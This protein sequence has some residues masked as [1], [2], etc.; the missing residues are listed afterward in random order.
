M[1]ILPHHSYSRTSSSL[2]PTWPHC[3]PTTSPSP[4]AHKV[5]INPIIKMGASPSIKRYKLQRAISPSWI[6]HEPRGILR[7]HPEPAYKRPQEKYVITWQNRKQR[8]R[9]ANLWP[10]LPLLTIPANCILIRPHRSRRIDA[11]MDGR[12]RL[13]ASGPN[14]PATFPTTLP[15]PDREIDLLALRAVK[16][17]DSRLGRNGTV[18]PDPT[19]T[20]TMVHGSWINIF[21]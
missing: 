9:V 6:T 15:K 11:L 18:A 5:I 19:R 8:A 13:S 10:L 14:W 21:L 16:Y 20:T 1:Q 4:L 12:R 2:R 7:A 17:R 3:H